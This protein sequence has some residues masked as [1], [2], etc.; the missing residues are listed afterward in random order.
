MVNFDVVRGRFSPPL[1]MKTICGCLFH[2]R[3]DAEKQG[4]V[5]FSATMDESGVP[6]VLLGKPY[7][8]GRINFFGY[9]RYSD[10][11]IRRNMVL[12][13]G[14]PLDSEQLRNSLEP[15]QSLRHVRNH[16][17]APGADQGHA[18]PRS[19]R[20]QHPP[21]RTQA[22]RMELLRPGAAHRFHQHAPARRGESDVFELSSYAVS[23]NMLAYSSLLK[24][25]AAKR[26]LPI[27]ALERPFTPGAGWLSGFALLA[28][29]SR[30]ADGGKLSV[31]AIRPA[32]TAAAGRNSAVRIS[33]DFKRPAG[34]EA[35]LI[36]E[37][38]KPRFYIP[39]MVLGIG[40]Q[41]GPFVRRLLSNVGEYNNSL[42]ARHRQ[43]HPERI[44]W[45]TPI[46]G[47]GRA[48]ERPGN[49]RA[50]TQ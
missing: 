12:D 4:I 39:R 7:T 13:E 40:L 31:H 28:A 41:R 3:R 44:R 21:G 26:F 18:S 23:F 34:G 35:T 47:Q 37:S 11:T 49:R 46:A 17:R 42:H 50:A 33:G 2:Q 10:S 19:G 6:K 25:T 43:Y 27:L 29:N 8:V 48:I 45:Q 36:C 20:H 1:D 16:R 9:K 22:R 38:P 5:D 24:L 30:Q 14:A 15:S 32:H